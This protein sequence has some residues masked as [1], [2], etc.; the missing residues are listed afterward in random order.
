VRREAIAPRRFR[1]TEE[2]GDP[3]AHPAGESGVAAA[4]C[5]RTPRRGAT[6]PRAT[7]RQLPIRAGQRPPT[8]LFL[9]VTLWGKLLVI[10]W[11]VGAGHAGATV[12]VEL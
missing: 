8:H 1:R 3:E 5:H 12:E 2:P 6:S 4:L 10:I 7:A 9:P 11:F